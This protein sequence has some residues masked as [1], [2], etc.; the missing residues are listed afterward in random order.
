MTEEILDFEW[1]QKS[2]D[3]L[4]IHHVIGTNKFLKFQLEYIIAGCFAGVT[5]HCLLLPFDNIK[6]NRSNSYSLIIFFYLFI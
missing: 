5:E 4:F 1:E 2:N 3:T 6:V